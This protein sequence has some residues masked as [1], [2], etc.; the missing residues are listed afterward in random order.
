[1]ADQVT[2]I[3]DTEDGL[4]EEVVDRSI[5]Y[6][7]LQ[8]RKIRQIVTPLD[9]LDQLLTLDVS[10]N[11]LTKLPLLPPQLQVLN[12]DHNQ[13]TSLLPSLSIL[14]TLYCYLGGFPILLCLRPYGKCI[15]VLIV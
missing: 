11:Q 8:G 3:L 2:L 6:L 1:M 10:I 9:Q 7:W 13:L 12:C 4:V 5:T 15:V 14:T